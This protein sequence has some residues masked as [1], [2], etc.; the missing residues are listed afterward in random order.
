L[1]AQ[2]AVIQVEDDH[3]LLRDAPVNRLGEQ[4]QLQRRSEHDECSQ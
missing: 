3:R 1:A 2:A 4:D